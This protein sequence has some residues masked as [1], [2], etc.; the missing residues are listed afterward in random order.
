MDAGAFAVALNSVFS[1]SHKRRGHIEGDRGVP[2]QRGRPFGGGCGN[3]SR[4]HQT[5][6]CYRD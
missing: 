5:R 6:N 3:L 1:R 4:C 2:G